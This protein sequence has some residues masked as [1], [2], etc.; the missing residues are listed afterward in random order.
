MNASMK[1]TLKI[2][3]AKDHPLYID[4]SNF[5][6]A[7]VYVNGIRNQH[8]TYYASTFLKVLAEMIDHE[9]QNNE[10]VS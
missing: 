7:E 3:N 5:F 2:F 10:R 6:D 4:L 1:T 8:L 9:T